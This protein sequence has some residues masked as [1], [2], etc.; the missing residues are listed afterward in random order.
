ML[1]HIALALVSG[2][3]LFFSWPVGGFPYLIFV[4]F[5]PL[6]IAERRIDQS[7]LKRKT[8]TFL[9]LVFL[10][11]LI[12]NIATTWWI[13]YASAPGAIAAIVLNSLFMTVF[14]ALYRYLKKHLV[15]V[16][17]Q[18]GFI[19]LW[20]F[21]EYFHLHWD[22]S[23]PWLTLGNVFAE[24]P[25]VVQWYEYTGVLGGSLWVL[26][27]NLIIYRSIF[28][29]RE[30]TNGFAI[31]RSAVYFTVLFLIPVGGS[32][33]LYYNEAA[34]KGDVKRIGVVQPNVDPYSEK[35]ADTDLSAAERLLELI[36]PILSDSIDVVLTPETSLPQ[37]IDERSL[38]R[39]PAL[40]RVSS[41][42]NEHPNTEMVVGASSY[43][44]Y[45]AD[46]EPSSTARR[47]GDG[48]FYYDA[49]NTAFH[50]RNNAHVETYHKSRL[51]VGVEKIPFQ[52]VL[53]SVLGETLID[54]G[55][56]TGTL[57]TQEAAEVFFTSDSSIIGAPLICYESVYGDYVGQ[58]V[59]QG[60]NVL[61]IITNDGWWR[62]TQGHQQHLAYARLRSIETRKW[63]ARSANTGI[64]AF[65]NSRGDVLDRIEYGEKGVLVSDVEMNSRVTLYAQYGDYIG[66][67]AGFMAVMFLLY[68]FVA[69]RKGREIGDRFQ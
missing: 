13:W 59:Q 69:S 60:A 27:V 61:F 54:L 67:L 3:I 22:I 52:S 47:S 30:T 43:Y 18:M 16:K 25:S 42:Q 9:G 15:E 23:W 24:V 20:L 34:Y 10:A 66:R 62:K 12:W 56:T 6:W 8:L 14:W 41:F 53:Q 58:F 40:Q 26:L 57:G 44:I 36:T 55:G 51:V 4:G 39:N 48:T 17:A 32:L 63:V 37:G 31:R 35:F 2:L 45:G 19:A 46:E 64:S 33:Q 38:L 50:L 29:F 7:A 5:V 68:A 1:F 49:Y 21:W 28:Q 11:L 65:I